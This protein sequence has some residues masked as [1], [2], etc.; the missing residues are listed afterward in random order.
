LDINER[1][2][3]HVLWGNWEKSIYRF[4]TDRNQYTEMGWTPTYENEHRQWNLRQSDRDLIKKFIAE[5]RTLRKIQKIRA[6][7]PMEGVK[8]APVSWKLIEILDREQQGIGKLNSSE[9][10]TLSDARSRARKCFNQYKRA[11]EKQK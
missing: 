8:Y 7:H 4:V 6:P 9:R 3:I 2:V 10:S 5:I 1:T 11:L